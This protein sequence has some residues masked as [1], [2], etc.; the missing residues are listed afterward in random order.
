MGPQLWQVIEEDFGKVRDTIRRERQPDDLKRIPVHS[1]S[2]DSQAIWWIH[3]DTE[4]GR[5][6]R[7]T[8]EENDARIVPVTGDS[9][10]YRGYSTLNLKENSPGMQRTG[11]G[12]LVCLSGSR[13]NPSFG[14]RS[15]SWTDIF[16]LE[17]RPQE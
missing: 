7:R 16:Q 6:I 8:S 4:V 13:R 10:G 14:Q 17:T 9:P 3:Q 1:G 11:F 15:L 12:I 2:N 5:T